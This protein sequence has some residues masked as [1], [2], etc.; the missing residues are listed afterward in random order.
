MKVYGIMFLE[1]TDLKKKISQVRFSDSETYSSIVNPKVTETG[2]DGTCGA[3]HVVYSH[4]HL[5]N[6]RTIVFCD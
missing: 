4:P 1:Y 3:V 2:R 5:K 6:K